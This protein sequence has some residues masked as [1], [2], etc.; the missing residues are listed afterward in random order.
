MPTPS[1]ETFYLLQ[2]I[3]GVIFLLGGWLFLRPKRPESGFKVR[4][5]DLKKS[6]SMK[7]EPTKREPIKKKAPLQLPGIRLDGHPHEILGI[8]AEASASEIQSAYRNLMKRYHPDRVGR[9]GSWQWHEAQKIAEAINHA[10]D[11]MLRRR[12]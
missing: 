11:E 6:S 3:L 1:R 5:A 4:E 7:K 10:K 2:I 12:S 9:Q 8:S